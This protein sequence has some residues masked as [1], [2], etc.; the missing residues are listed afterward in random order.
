MT[1]ADPRKVV[2]EFADSMA[3]TSR[4]IGEHGDAAAYETLAA[5]TLHPA[6]ILTMARQVGQA[7]AARGYPEAGACV[8]LL[9]EI[10]DGD[11]PLHGEAELQGPPVDGR[12]VDRAPEDEPVVCGA[13]HEKGGICE[14]ALPHKVHMAGSVVWRTEPPEDHPQTGDGE[15]VP[16]VTSPSPH[17]WLRADDPRHHCWCL[18]GDDHV[19]EPR[20]EKES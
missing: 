10:V 1:H 6:D 13:A 17:L 20:F 12:E 16:P 3:A 11:C 15:A 7:M 18:I 4:R 9:A 5:Q 8:Q 2:A 19:A 14:L